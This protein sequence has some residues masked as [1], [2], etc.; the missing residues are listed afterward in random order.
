MKA[1]DRPNL[2]LRD[3]EGNI[4]GVYA[5]EYQAIEAAKI[6][7]EATYTLTR[8]TAT[9]E[10]GSGPLVP[11]EFAPTAPSGLIATATSSTS[12]SLGSTP[13]S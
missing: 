12:I 6:V 5:H 1:Y 3:A 4:V 2:T 7:G 11:D 10:G 9:Y 13:A 8:P